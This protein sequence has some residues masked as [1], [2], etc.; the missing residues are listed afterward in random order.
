MGHEQKIL[1][2]KFELE[3]ASLMAPQGHRL[4]GNM[5]WK[6]VWPYDEGKEINQSILKEISPECSLEGL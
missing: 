4:C 3:E 5:E 6:A 1:L 2:V